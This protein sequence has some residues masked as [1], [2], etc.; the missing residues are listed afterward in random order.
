[1]VTLTPPGWTMDLR[2]RI[3]RRRVD[4]EPKVLFTVADLMVLT[5]LSRPRIYQLL[6]AGRGP[7]V[8]YI[9]RPGQ[10]PFHLFDPDEAREWAAR[11][12]EARGPA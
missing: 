5:G 12:R 7:R 2:R 11:R 1:M 10:H 4:D 6:A 3:I 8:A 9:A